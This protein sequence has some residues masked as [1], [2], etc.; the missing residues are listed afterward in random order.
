V[1]PGNDASE[2]PVTFTVVDDDTAGVAI[3]PSEEVVAEPV[4]P[5]SSEA[6][7]TTQ[8]PA[9]R[10]HPGGP[11]A[12][13]PLTATFYDRSSRYREVAKASDRGASSAIEVALTKTRV[14]TSP[15]FPVRVSPERAP[16]IPIRQLSRHPY[17]GAGIAAAISTAEIILT[18][19]RLEGAA[20]PPP[21]R[22]AHSPDGV[23]RTRAAAVLEKSRVRPARFFPVPALRSAAP[24]VA[25]S[26]VPS[27]PK[28][29]GSY[30]SRPVSGKSQSHAAR[31]AN[32]GGGGNLRTGPAS[33]SRSSRAA[34]S[35]RTADNRPPARPV[36][37]RP[38][39]R[40]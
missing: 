21:S 24:S 40:P 4:S 6:A 13:I 33:P 18:K 32:S 35:S 17:S 20:L 3:T 16:E 25:P 31:R 1:P 39:G 11:S 34:L 5:V 22:P 26:P 27:A 8:V 36:N 12:V 9:R 15:R 10:P 23:I 30:P 7:V 2:E 37:R 38:S 14:R 28:S 29:S 19:T